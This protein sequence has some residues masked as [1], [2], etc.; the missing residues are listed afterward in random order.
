MNETVTDTVTATPT[1]SGGLKC[2]NDGPWIVN[3]SFEDSPW[4]GAWFPSGSV[5]RVN[6]GDDFS[7]VVELTNGAAAGGVVP[8]LEQAIILP[9][10]RISGVGFFYRRT[11]GS[12]DGDLK[13]TFSLGSY[14]IPGSVVLI[15]N[16]EEWGHAI[17]VLESL[18]GNL[19]CVPMVF[20]IG[21]TVTDEL[22]PLINPDGTK[23]LQIDGL[24]FYIS[25]QK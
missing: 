10:G 5:D 24:E 11:I 7:L 12:D 8:Q 23:V 14:Y 16:E 20:S 21:V 17:V 4:P 2:S 6:S 15:A 18:N 25:L 1:P 3:P 13:V 9:H 22:S 19:E